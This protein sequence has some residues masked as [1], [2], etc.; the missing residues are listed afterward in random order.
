MPKGIAPAEHGASVQLERSGMRNLLL[1]VLIVALDLPSWAVVAGERVS[2]VLEYV[3]QAGPGQYDAYFGYLNNNAVAVTIPV[4]AD[5]RFT[6]VQD[7]GQPSV[8]QPGR[9]VAVFVVRFDGNDLVWTLKGPDGNTR[10]VTASKNNVIPP[11]TADLSLKATGLINGQ[12]DAEVTFTVTNLGPYS[13]SSAK[14]QISLPGGFTLVDSVAEEGATQRTPTGLQWDLAGLASKASRWIRVITRGDRTQGNTEV[15]G[16]CAHQGPDPEPSNNHASYTITGQAGGAADNGLESNG[17]LAL[18]LAR[19]WALRETGGPRGKSRVR[20]AEGRPGTELEALLPA[21]GPAE[22]VAVASSPTDLIGVTNAA[23]VAG[24]DYVDGG[25]NR[26][27]AVL[28]IATDSGLYEHSK[29]VCE[30]VAR[31]VLEQIRAIRV[32]GL[33]F[34]M[35]KIRRGEGA[36]E[37]AVSFAVSPAGVPWRID[38][39]W[40]PGLAPRFHGTR[41]LNFQVWAT[42]AE[43]AEGL[44]ARLLE[45]MPRAVSDDPDVAPPAVFVRSAR[46]QN[47][48][49]RLE[50][51]GRGA[52]VKVEGSLALT[53]P[54]QRSWVEYELPFA[55]T[56][57]IRTGPFFDFDFRIGEDPVYVADGAWSYWVAPEDG[58]VAEFEV[59]AQP[60]NGPDGE[61]VAVERGIRAAGSVET[62]VS[63]FR[64]LLPKALPVDLRRFAAIE[65]TA[66]GE[67]SLEVIPVKASIRTPAAQYR[68]RFRLTSGGERLRLDLTG[69]DASDVTTLYFN[70]LGAGAFDLRIED[71]RLIPGSGE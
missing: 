18:L 9:Q 6:G 16:S 8:F 58:R 34:L 23:A 62:Y 33:P 17:R 49:L 20:L 47:G 65:F 54:G 31:G 41:V 53:E 68:Q 7:R 22:T 12:G 5:N 56:V 4:G 24:A 57:T 10:T 35:A 70:V 69:F 50:L 61:G 1:V 48:A 15:R 46:Y 21:S 43:F 60:S 45:R 27:G 66:A 32:S 19:R 11:G 26:Q 42:N 51:E 29:A 64:H 63:F 52:S 14:V 30:R 59:L 39:R 36:I 40:N 38:S 28:A 37:Y 2:P 67:G 13:A 25:G 3:L 44:V 71:L 55:P